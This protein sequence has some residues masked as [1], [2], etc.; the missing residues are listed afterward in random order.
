MGCSMGLEF[1]ITHALGEG[2]PIAS[3]VRRGIIVVDELN[4]VV[5]ENRERSATN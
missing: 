3:L 1:C 4:R 5:N 2:C